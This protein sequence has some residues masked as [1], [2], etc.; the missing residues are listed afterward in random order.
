MTGPKIPLFQ[1]HH[2]PKLGQPLKP[3][4]TFSLSI[5]FPLPISEKVG[6]K[7]QRNSIHPFL[8]VWSHISLQIC[9]PF[10]FNFSKPARILLSSN[11]WWLN[12]KNPRE[13][14]FGATFLFR[15]ENEKARIYARPI[16]IGRVQIQRDRLISSNNHPTRKGARCEETP[17]ENWKRSSKNRWIQRFRPWVSWFSVFQLVFTR[18]LSNPWRKMGTM[19]LN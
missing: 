13:H 1:P 17:S 4:Y 7:P 2:S 5:A 11:F 15:T 19:A 12:I 14:C 10:Y 3:A 9:S 16:S 8:W 18:L 6:E